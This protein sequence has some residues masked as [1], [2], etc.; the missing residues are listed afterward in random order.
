MPITRTYLG[1][2]AQTASQTTHTLPVTIGSGTSRKLI[3]AGLRE[4][5]QTF[6]ALTFDGTSVFADIAVD[7]TH[8]T[9]SIVYGG[10]WFHDIPDAKGAGSYNIVMTTSAGTT[11][12]TLYAWEL[13][14]AATGVPEDADFA[15]TVTTQTATI[16][17]DC[18][19]GA[20]I[21]SALVGASASSTHSW[22]GNVTE[23]TELNEANYT[24]SVAEG[25]SSGAGSRTSVSTLS[26]TGVSVQ[27]SVSVAPAAVGPTIEDQP[28]AQTKILTNANTASFSVTAT[29]TGTL[30]YDW[31]LEDGVGSGVYANLANGNGATWTGQASASCS[32]TLTAKTLTGRRVRCNVTDDNGTTTTNA[33]ALTIWDGPQVTTF[34]ATNGSGVSTATL[35]SDY[36]TGVG[37]AIEVRIPLSDGDVAVTVTTT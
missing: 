2:F 4:A 3:I 36:V 29:G 18:S 12:V 34:P 22:S 35:T 9:T 20:S 26:A 19:D 5:S 37:E 31:E 28:G 15:E 10:L 23:T 21:T 8:S 6:T 14:G 27:L 11:N 24:T 13:T 30:L 33:V 25:T 32:A 1:S 17:L 7:R 16:T